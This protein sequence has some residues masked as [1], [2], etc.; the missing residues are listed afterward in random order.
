MSHIPSSLQDVFRAWANDNTHGKDLKELAI[1][2]RRKAVVGKHNFTDIHEG[3]TSKAQ[4][5]GLL[6]YDSSRKR[7]KMS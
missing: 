6:R 3:A 7:H 1:N 2:L 4:K 5:N